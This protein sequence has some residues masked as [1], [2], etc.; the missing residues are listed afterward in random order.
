[1]NTEQ[2]STKELEQMLAK[3]KRE[4]HIA[5]VK[6][7]N[8]YEEKKHAVV[9]SLTQEAIQL[10]TALTNFKEKVHTEMDAQKERLDHFG[11]IRTNSKGGFSIENEDK[12]LKVSRIRQT[13]PKWD[14]KS[15][16]AVELISDFLRD[17][18]KKRDLKMFDILMSFIEK[19]EKGDL[20]YSRVMDL[21][22]HEDKFDDERWHEGLRLIK[23]SYSLD[24]RGYSYLFK[25]KN[26]EE[27]W[28]TLNLNFSSL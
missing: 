14:E 17:T 24:F 3:R 12:T 27:K 23:N 26:Q 28:D 7:E 21:I 25:A 18:V 16:K 19:N 4:E 13:T 5:R 9:N 1:M 11:K 15:K 22:S 20:E 6:E 8:E 2:L 10:F